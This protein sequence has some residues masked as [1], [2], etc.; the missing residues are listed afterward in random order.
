ME[1]WGA[2]SI[3]GVAVVLFVVSG[4]G[5][6]HGDGGD[7]DA[8]SDADIDPE[9]CSTVEDPLSP[10]ET[11]GA[12][13]GVD[14]LI[15]AADQLADAAAEHAGHRDGGGHRSEVV[16]ISEALDDGHGGILVDEA[17]ETLRALIADGRPFQTPGCPGCN[18]PYYNERPGGPMYNYPHPLSAGKAATEVAAFLDDLVDVGGPAAVDAGSG[19]RI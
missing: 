19:P 16:A 8:D 3:V 2:T 12:P 11:P 9:E 14:Y 17:S 6:D 7:G 13:D 18:R 10:P 4:L 15:I 1:R 5:C